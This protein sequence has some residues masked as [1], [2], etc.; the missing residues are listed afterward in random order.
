MSEIEYTSNLG[1]PS[2]A[3]ASYYRHGTLK[4]LEVAQIIEDAEFQ[5][6]MVGI[7]ACKYYGGVDD[8]K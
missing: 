6:C 2:D 7:S 3:Q 5:C 1:L 8:A 4:I